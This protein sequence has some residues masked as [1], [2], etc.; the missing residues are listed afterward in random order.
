LQEYAYPYAILYFPT[1]DWITAHVFLLWPVHI[2][3]YF[4]RF[5]FA[6]F[7]VTFFVFIFF[8]WRFYT[9][10]G[11]EFFVGLAQ[12]IF[13]VASA[14]FYYLTGLAPFLFFIL[15]STILFVAYNYFYFIPRSIF[16]E[17][18]SPQL[19]LP[20]PARQTIL[21]LP[22]F[23][24]KYPFA[25]QLQAARPAHRRAIRFPF[26]SVSVRGVAKHHRFIRSVLNHT[27]LSRL[28][29]PV[30]TRPNF[31]GSG[32]PFPLVG[33]SFEEFFKFNPYDY[34]I[35]DFR[36]QFIFQSDLPE[37]PANPGQDFRHEDEEF[38]RVYRFMDFPL[39]T[40][41][42]AFF[43]SNFRSARRSLYGNH[44]TREFDTF[45]AGFG[46]R[47][48]LWKMALIND[49]YFNLY[50]WLKALSPATVGKTPS[51]QSSYYYYFQKNYYS[52]AAAP[53]PTVFPKLFFILNKI[54]GALGGLLAFFST[55]EFELFPA[56]YANCS[57]LQYYFF[58]AK[59]ATTFGKLR[60]APSISFLRSAVR[61]FAAFERRLDSDSALRAFFLDA[62][63]FRHEL[64]HFFAL[65][66]ASALNFAKNPAVA[67]NPILFF[68][69]SLL[70]RFL[71]RLLFRFT[72]K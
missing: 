42:I 48:P 27:Y 13:F 39:W 51:L 11:F 60:R 46:S 21:F 34:Q 52:F 41:N 5:C 32:I 61:F 67:K 31:Y 71:N 30:T 36:S 24:Y 9:R 62:P 43:G 8:H 35:H 68:H 17:R 33:R 12:A 20:A 25:A 55:R 18:L 22:H 7:S 44:F 6:L 26:Y 65:F 69:Y 66:H 2:D 28:S 19:F 38:F 1:L 72:F 40:N 56:D 63:Q 47:P 49:P 59:F 15:F 50:M 57:K 70:L 64:T 37:H 14:F 29:T 10:R 58:I 23:R 4:I 53:A 54:Y 45:G 16:S 3:F